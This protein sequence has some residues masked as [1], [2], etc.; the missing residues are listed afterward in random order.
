MELLM[1][2]R[3][4]GQNLLATTRRQFLKTVGSAALLACAHPFI[5]A[6]GGGSGGET[7]GETD[8]SAAIEKMTSYIEQQMTEKQVTGLAIALVDDQRVVW[9]R[10]FGYADVANRIE[11]TTDTLFGIGSTSK[12]FAAAMIMQLVEQGLINLDD[13]LTMYIPGFS[14]GA[15]IGPY[16]SAGGPITVRTVLTQHSGIP[17]DLDNGLNT[18]SSHPDYNSRMVDYLQGDYA[19]YPTDYFFAYSNTAVALLGDIIAAASGEAFFDYSN[20]FLRSLGMKHSSFNRDDPSVAVGKAKTY[21]KGEEVFDGYLNG[22]AAGSIISCVSDMAKYIKMIHAGGTAGVNRVLQAATVETMLSPKNEAVPLDFD[23]RIGY[24]WWL[25]DPDLAYAGRLCDHAGDT[26]ASHTALKILR[27]HK[28]GVVV[29]TNSDTGGKIRNSVA[30]KTLQLAVEA[31]AGLKPTTF[32]PEF[33][34]VVS[35]SV[36]RLEALAGIYIPVVPATHSYLAGSL[37][38]SWYDRIVRSTDGLTW[39]ENA[40]S[41]SPVAKVL[42][43]RANGRFSAPDSQDIEYEFKNVSGRNVIVRHTKGFKSL[44]ADRYEPVSI[45][46]AWADRVGSYAP[47]NWDADNINRTLPDFSEEDLILKMEIKDGMLLM[48]GLPLAPVSDTKAYAPGL[49]RDLGSAFQVV[50]V[51]GEEYI[52]S[53]NQLLRKG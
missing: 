16:S 22:Y 18:S 1:T 34:P 3:I 37:P 40:G 50:N 15:P 20:A 43:P 10:G 38:A 39:I 8:Y 24:I 49:A 45:P 13:P 53:K 42:V 17:G 35:W 47:V 14:L 26:V 23:F 7:G 31:K 48:G 4:T 44:A 2:I 46:S 9:S 28:L 41:T 5:T 32:V 51:N 19:L 33:S 27:D 36:D 52:Q 12:T 30:V 11:S 29:L 6:C 21:Y 25:F